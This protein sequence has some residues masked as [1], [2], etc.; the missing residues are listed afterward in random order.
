M[1][2]A[3]AIQTGLAKSFQYSGRASRAEYWWFLP[4]G[5]LLPVVALAGVQWLAPT[6]SFLLLCGALFAALSPLMAVTRRRLIDSG[7]S[8]SWFEVPLMALVSFLAAVW[9]LGSL[10]GWAI[11]AWDAGADGP[12]GFAVF[13]LWLLGFA[14]L[15]PITAQQFL[16]GFATG[17]ALFSQMASPSSMRHQFPGPNPSEATP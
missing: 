5:A 16:T 14:V 4:V 2:P 8:T 6:A 3:Q 13:I 17:I 15:V 12:A 11:A 1:G 9:A 7:E 10:H